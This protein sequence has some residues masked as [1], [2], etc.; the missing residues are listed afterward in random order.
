MI[1]TKK[2]SMGQHLLAVIGESWVPISTADLI[3]ICAADKVNAR[4]WVW[5]EL[6]KL[7]RKGL[8][9]KIFRKS[10]QTVGQ[11]ANQTVAHWILA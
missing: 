10:R 1:A 5:T 2:L 6:V 3:A 8:I 7:Q 9:E 4:G 11:G